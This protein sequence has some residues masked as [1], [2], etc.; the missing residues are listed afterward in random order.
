MSGK[1]FNLTMANKAAENI[2]EIE[3]VQIIIKRLVKT[4][5][6]QFDIFPL[7]KII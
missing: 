2:S 5:C 7:A 6:I 1:S 3:A 4:K